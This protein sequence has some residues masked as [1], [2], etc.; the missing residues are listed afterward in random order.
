MQNLSTL[1][2]SISPLPESWIERMFDKM[3]LDYGK[4]FTDN[5]A[6]SDPQRLITHWSNEMASYSGQEIKRGLAA[7]ENRD[8]PP[9]LPEFKKMCRPPIDPMVAYYEAV[10]GVTA[11]D[12]GEAG[13]WSHPAVFWAATSLSFDLKSLSYSQIKTRWEMALDDQMSKGEWEPIPKPMLALPDIGKAQLSKE[14]A[15][16][17]IDELGATNATKKATS[18]TDHL[19]WAKKIKER[20]KRGDK[21]L[22][23]ISIRFA[24]EALSA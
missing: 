2:T 13:T 5:W 23:S 22:L 12:R 8:W 7:M 10:N 24:N 6:G 9:S 18:K 1:S 17:L 21:H 3:L 14:N 16:K 11:R 15:A 19:R 4:K 20:E